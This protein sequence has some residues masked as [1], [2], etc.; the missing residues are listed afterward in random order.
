MYDINDFITLKAKDA[1]TQKS[2]L[3]E[4]TRRCLNSEV[5]FLGILEKDG[6]MN[7][8]GESPESLT[9]YCLLAVYAADIASVPYPEGRARYVERLR[10]LV[11]EN[12][13]SY[14]KVVYLTKYSNRVLQKLEDM[15]ASPSIVHE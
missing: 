14:D 1:V 8:T 6:L 11:E 13:L 2:I 3:D 9:K 7:V 5:D 15:W 10:Q 4:F 12:D